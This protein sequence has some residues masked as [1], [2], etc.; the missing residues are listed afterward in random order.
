MKKILTLLFAF[1]VATAVASDLTFVVTDATGATSTGAIDMSVA[2]GVSP[3]T[4]NWS[5]PSGFTA[6]TEDIGGLASGTYTV[7]VT[8]LYCGIATYTVFVDVTT[9]IA[10]KNPGPA[11]SVFPNPANSHI[12]ISSG[13]PLKDATVKLIGL[14]GK[15]L[16]EE[17][18]ISGNSFSMDIS[19]QTSG[20][21]FIEINNAGIFSRKRFVKE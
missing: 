6:N 13:D 14:N 21:Y 10:E 16:V 4:Y 1:S 18:N 7:T 8:D 19:K 11:L 12:T 9:G 2:G 3:Y 17:K 20:I 5:G 15:T